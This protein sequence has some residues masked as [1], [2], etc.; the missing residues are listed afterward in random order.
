MDAMRLWESFAPAAL[1]PGANEARECG[2]RENVGSG[3]GIY[4]VEL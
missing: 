4:V 3:G 1:N 2:H